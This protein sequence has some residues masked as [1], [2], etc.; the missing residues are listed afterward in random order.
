MW[1]FDLYPRFTTI[2]NCFY[3]INFSFKCFKVY[4]QVSTTVAN[5]RT[6]PTCINLPENQSFHYY[7]HLSHR[8]L[9]SRTFLFLQFAWVP[10]KRRCLPCLHILRAPQCCA[11]VCLYVL[12]LCVT[13]YTA[14]RKANNLAWLVQLLHNPQRLPLEL[15]YV[16]QMM[17]K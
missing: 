17:V 16:L 9:R 8:L 7:W 6:D 14:I 2:D 11:N 15:G 5:D 3:L 10:I 1:C 12:F 13:C 4:D